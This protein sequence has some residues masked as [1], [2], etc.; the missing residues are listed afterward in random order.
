MYETV[1]LIR[2]LREPAIVFK[3]E[4]A[5][6][7]VWG[8]IARRYGTIP[9]DRN[10]SAAALRV[11]L[12]AAKQAKELG[13]PI[14]IFPEGSR[15]RPG[16][17]PQ[18]RPGFAGLYRQLGLPVIPIAVDSGEYWLRKQ[19]IKRPGMITFR[20]GDPI[21]PGLSRTEAEARVHAGINALEH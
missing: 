10:G 7:P 1:E 12:R 21:P 14:V 11:M 16:N 15:V 19:F 5:D 17:Q 4:L 18:L 2:M 6:L 20:F 8:W 13:R 3:K 9:V